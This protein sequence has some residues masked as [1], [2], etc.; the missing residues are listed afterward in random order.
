MNGYTMYIC[1]YV[2]CM[3]V[4]VMCSVFICDW[5]V[6]V[7]AGDVGMHPCSVCMYRYAY[8][9]VH[10]CCIYECMHAYV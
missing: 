3:C 8:I 1:I 10:V 6:F 5:C 7:A 2:I 9:Y 4:C